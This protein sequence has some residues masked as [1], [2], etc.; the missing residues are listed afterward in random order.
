MRNNLETQQNEDIEMLIMSKLTPLSTIARSIAIQRESKSVTIL[1]RTGDSLASVKIGITGDVQS[2]LF[3]G[4]MAVYQSMSFINDNG[5]IEIIDLNNDI[6][7]LLQQLVASMN[8]N[9]INRV[10]PA[11]KLDESRFRCRTCYE[12]QIKIGN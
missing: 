8:K 5:I 7:E 9:S 1:Q 2:S 11:P 10:G 6:I 12:K 3:D 4:M